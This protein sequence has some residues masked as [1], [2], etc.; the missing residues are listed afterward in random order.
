[1]SGEIYARPQRAFTE[2]RSAPAAEEVPDHEDDEYHRTGDDDDFSPVETHIA[3]ALNPFSR[4]LLLSTETDE[5]DMA[6]LA[7]TGDR[8]QPVAG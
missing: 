5:S 2:G 1:M 3:G 4:K 7:I 6:A 8:S